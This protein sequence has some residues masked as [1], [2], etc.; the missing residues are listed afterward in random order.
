MLFKITETLKM[1]EMRLAETSLSAATELM[2]RY[3]HDDNGMKLTTEAFTALID[4]MDML[5]FYTLWGQFLG[6]AV[7][8]AS[9][10]P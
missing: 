10:R 9:A 1:R 5:Q 3:A 7:P 8:K 4:D 2:G 6:S